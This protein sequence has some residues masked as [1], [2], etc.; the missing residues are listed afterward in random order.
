MT[1]ICTTAISTLTQ[2]VTR[3][4][5]ALHQNLTHFITKCEQLYLNDFVLSFYRFFF[6][7]Y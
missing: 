5:K 4:Y 7:S 6:Y 2:C 1:Q 3:T